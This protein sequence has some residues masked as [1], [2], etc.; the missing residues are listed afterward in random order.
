MV[1]KG[2][3]RRSEAKRGV[4]EME[5]RAEKAPGRRRGSGAWMELRQGD[6]P[7]R[8]SYSSREQLGEA[9]PESRRGEEEGGRT[10]TRGEGRRVEDGLPKSRTRAS[11]GKGRY[12]LFFYDFTKIITFTKLSRKMTLN[13]R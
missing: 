9:S 10:R 12:F 1:A 7:T 6:D 4:P 5:R 2:D 11:N 3:A 8:R 13:R